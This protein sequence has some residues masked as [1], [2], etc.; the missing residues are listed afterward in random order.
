MTE[1]TTEPAAAASGPS[2]SLLPSLVKACRPKQWAKNVLV[3]VAPAAAGVITE[4]YRIRLTLVAFVAFCMVSSATYLLNDVLD[5]S[6]IE[7]GRLELENA[8]FQPGATAQSIADL[9][10]ARVRDKGLQFDLKLGE[11]LPGVIIGD[12]ARLR[13]IIVNLLGNAIKFTER[14]SVELAG[15]VFEG[16]FHIGLGEAPEFREHFGRDGAHRVLDKGLV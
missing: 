10:L 16:A 1:Q 14:G 13:Q 11:N 3:F 4:P 12:S 9:M 5:F 2:A 6:K 8:P 15:A 7:S